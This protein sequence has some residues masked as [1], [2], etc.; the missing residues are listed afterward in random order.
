MESFGIHGTAQDCCSEAIISLPLHLS[1][2]LSPTLLLDE[3]SPPFPGSLPSVSVLWEPLRKS[4]AVVFYSLFLAAFLI[5]KPFGGTCCS[6]LNKEKLLVSSQVILFFVYQRVPPRILM[7]Y[8]SDS[9]SLVIPAP[10][11]FPN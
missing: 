9:A 3:M 4:F 2:I 11:H 8:F 10:L 5:C 1:L 7:M 6:L